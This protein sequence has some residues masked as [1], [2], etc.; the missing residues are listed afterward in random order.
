[1]MLTD[2]TNNN[3][4]SKSCKRTTALQYFGHCVAL[5]TK[6]TYSFS[7]HILRRHVTRLI[8]EKGITANM[9]VLHGT[10]KMKRDSKHAIPCSANFGGTTCQKSNHTLAYWGVTIQ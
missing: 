10:F 9:V 8:Q 5:S 4:R 3:G 2:S 6:L 1:M 7:G